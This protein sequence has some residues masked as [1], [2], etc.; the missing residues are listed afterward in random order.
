VFRSTPAITSLGTRR[1][2]VGRH[3]A[4]NVGSLE[5][6]SPIA[7]RCLGERRFAQGNNQPRR[8]TVVA[9]VLKEPIGKGS[10]RACFKIAWTAHIGCASKIL[11]LRSLRLP[12]ELEIVRSDRGDCHS[13]PAHP[14]RREATGNE[15]RTSSLT[16]L[17][18]SRR[19][20]SSR[21]CSCV[22]CVLARSLDSAKP[23]YLNRWR[24]FAL[25]HHAAQA[26]PPRRPSPAQVRRSADVIL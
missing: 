25:V 24:V 20:R 19:E 9:D 2:G 18:N 17:L 23:N 6:A 16:A 10:R 11:P 8:R 26:W 22:R 3:E 15:G 5:N 7:E 1:C 14:S 13:G 12:A 21:S 4:R